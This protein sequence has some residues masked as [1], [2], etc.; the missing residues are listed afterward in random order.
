MPRRAY[1]TALSPYGGTS[2][3]HGLVG[4]VPPRLVPQE[5]GGRGHAFRRAAATSGY[6]TLACPLGSPLLRPSESPLTVGEMLRLNDALMLLSISRKILS[7]TRL[8]L[9][10]LA[11]THP[12]HVVD[13]PG[14]LGLTLHLGR[15]EPHVL[16]GRLL[17][18]DALG[19]GLECGLHL[20]GHGRGGGVTPRDLEVL[21]PFQ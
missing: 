11:E 8:T 6:R 15:R 3:I 7:S 14:Q 17:M 13:V 16:A 21:E 19:L 10:P 4:P 5:Q 20:G 9:L 18:D 12:G 2:G 1:S